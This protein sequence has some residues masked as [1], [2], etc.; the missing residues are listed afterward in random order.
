MLDGD[1][2]IGILTLSAEGPMK[3]EEFKFDY[4]PQY[5]KQVSCKGIQIRLAEDVAGTLNSRFR[6]RQLA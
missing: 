5:G 2:E 6:F 3:V 4:S 1:E